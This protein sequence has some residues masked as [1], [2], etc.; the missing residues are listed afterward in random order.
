MAQL[1]STSITGS[2]IVT[3]GI[4]GSLFGTA[5]FV[6]SAS[7]ATT[8]S[9][10]PNT[11]VQGGNSFGGQALLGTNDNNS[12]ALET[13]GT[14]RL[15]INGI[16]QA[17]FSDIVTV[18]GGSIISNSSTGNS[19]VTLT[20]AGSCT[21]DMLNAQTEGYIRT[22]SNHDLYFRTNNINRMVIS[23]D[24]NI[25][26]GIPGTTSLTTR[27]QIRG[28]GATSS[29]TALR[30]ENSNASASL[31]VR[32][33]L[34]VGINNA[35]PAYT[36]DVDGNAQLG[37]NNYYAR[38]TSGGS[39]G[40]IFRV[41]GP[42]YGQAELT[43]YALSLNGGHGI[44]GTGGTSQFSIVSNVAPAAAQ[45]GNAGAAM[46]FIAENSGSGGGVWP[47]YS[48]ALAFNFLKKESDG[49]YTSTFSING[50]TN[51]IGIG[52]ITP[53]A[54]LH[55]SGASNVGLFEIDSPT[56]NNIIFVSGSGRV[57][58]GT[59]TPT[60]TLD[61]FRPLTG[62]GTIAT[63]Y[64][65]QAP[66]Q[67]EASI[68]VGAQS[69]DP[70]V[71]V[72]GGS[73]FSTL[74][75][76]FLQ[77]KNGQRALSFN[78]L[79]I[80]SIGTTQI[81]SSQYSALTIG[82]GASSISSLVPN[83]IGLQLASIPRTIPHN[84]P[85]TL[86]SEVAF[87]SFG[88]SSLSALVSATT[89]TN[90]YN[91]YIDGAPTAGSA[92]TFTNRYALY[93]NSGSSYFGDNVGI[94]ITNPTASLDVFRNNAGNIQTNN[95]SVIVRGN[96]PRLKILGTSAGNSTGD[97]VIQF[98]TQDGG[99]RWVI[100]GGGTFSIG[101]G[102]YNSNT[103]LFRITN[104]SGGNTAAS[105]FLANADNDGRFSLGFSGTNGTPLSGF[106]GT[107]RLFISSTGLATPSA[108]LQV[109]GSGAT[110]STT[111]FRVEN[112]NASASLV[113]RDNNNIGIGTGSAAYRLDIAGDTTLA[114][115]IIRIQPGSNAMSPQFIIDDGSERRLALGTNAGGGIFSSG[116]LNYAAVLGSPAGYS[117][118]F[119]TTNTARMTIL[120]ADGNV[121]IG[122]NAPTSRLHVSGAGS[123]GLRV[124]GLS[125]VGLTVQ[126]GNLAGG[127]GT[128]E[129]FAGNNNNSYLR[130]ASEF[131]REG[132]SGGLG[133]NVAREN[134]TSKFQVRG[135]GATSSTTALRVENSNFSASLVVLD[136]GRVGINTGSAAYT[137]DVNGIARVGDSTTSGQLY[138]KGFP[139][140]GQYIYLDDGSKVWSLIGGTNYT[141]QDTGTTRF[142]IR[143]GGNV[144]IGTG[145]PTF[146]LD[147]SGSGRFT[148]NVTVT[149]S[150]IID[151][152]LFD[153][154]T[155]GSL[156]SGSHLLY[157]FSTASY[158]AGFF[159]YYVISGSNFRAGTI[160]S[161]AG[162]GTYRFTDQATPDIGDTTNLQFSMSLDT[163][164]LQL[165][166]SA[167]SNSWTIKTT[168]R[169]I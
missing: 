135:S 16:G 169:T 40:G 38:L 154:I 92:V 36:L 81:S 49:T 131:I 153:T 29:T 127:S 126:A 159:D 77:T 55:I 97:G 151:G 128:V 72:L 11:F 136:N 32:D 116:N 53:T 14:T 147:V 110:S 129:L 34:R 139:G 33:D 65:Y 113:V 7:F 3:G 59:G 68:E 78:Q 8:A 62:T 18:N 155:T 158:Q 60:T 101:A 93:I 74:L 43:S 166:A 105:V 161:V 37:N 98:S 83:K 107:G 96:N 67:L 27:L 145:T 12:L 56:V 6:T 84:G 103:S 148:S 111:A 99:D 157:S 114:N 119:F 51:N 5:S 19:F 109:R 15:T 108:M 149:G 132:G 104:N 9:F 66:F 85:G 22:T 30:I 100:T 42:S 102:W 94:G 76:G 25:G 144:G 121:G 167:S 28:S 69:S 63:F 44:S 46:K 91:V 163:S 146:R 142:V 31:I 120:A 48:T 1:Q 26:M 52:T 133:I 118:Q 71:A 165:Y 143:E 2:L 41:G 61:V 112:S 122:T 134:I 125:S 4:T 141:I 156:P 39:D 137:L 117:I 160:M 58:I 82:G 24:G 73:N 123:T 124:D 90:A 80:V 21:M 13:N 75:G 168:F 95:D 23:K 54:R 138:V 140:A 150:V 20:S 86:Q 57:G 64:G 87:N 45:F 17:T 70:G 88:I 35:S 10:V 50:G 79:G 152:G 164:N 130:L 89:Y 47:A 115:N 162:A 106:T